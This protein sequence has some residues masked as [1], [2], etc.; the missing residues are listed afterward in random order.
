MAY[1]KLESITFLYILLQIIYI[2]YAKK[3]YHHE[4]STMLIMRIISY[5]QSML[6]ANCKYVWIH[7]SM[8]VNI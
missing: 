1:G 8:N 7:V 6:H 5:L 2:Y 3:N 4:M